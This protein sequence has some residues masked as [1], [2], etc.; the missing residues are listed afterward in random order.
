MHIYPQ[1][2][3]STL[4]LCYLLN[5]PVYSMCSGETGF[6]GVFTYPSP[7]A[8]PPSLLPSL[9]QN[10]HSHIAVSSVGVFICKLDSEYHG[11]FSAPL[12]TNANPL[13]HT[14]TVT[15]IAQTLPHHPQTHPYTPIHTP[16][17]TLSPHT[18]TQSDTHIHTYT[19]PHNTKT[20]IYTPIH[21]T[22]SLTSFCVLTHTNP[23]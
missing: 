17:P 21:T 2:P 15:H 6:S 4:H 9:C 16:T 13:T 12:Y 20:H 19:H 8:T 10:F 14:L 1:S 23:H 5:R 11:T 22:T 7:P 3:S 18:L